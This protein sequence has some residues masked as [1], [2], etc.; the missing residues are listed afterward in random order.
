MK[1]PQIDK[2]PKDL[3]QLDFFQEDERD[4]QEELNFL[5]STGRMFL[6]WNDF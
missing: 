3:E 5:E 4:E 2:N 6:T 1:E